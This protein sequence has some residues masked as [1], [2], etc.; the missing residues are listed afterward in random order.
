MSISMY[1][2][3]VLPCVRMLGNL[4]SI[5]QKGM[6]HAEAKKFDPAA[7]V[8]SRLF[9]DM[10]PL[11]RQVQIATDIAKGGLGRLA[12][13]EIPVFEDKETTF[14]ELME[15]LDRTIA[16]IESIKPEQL[17]GSE[18]RPLIMKT[19]RGGM[20]FDSGLDYLQHF[21]LPNVY[22]HAATTYNLLRH[23][24]VEVGKS[25]FIGPVRFV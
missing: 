21:V 25:D 2:A 16:F 12:G 5:L 23:N 24:G 13:V 8:G 3:S 10:F 11:S 19:P 22:F 18:S 17:D 15:R 1:Q 9:P 20:E 14:P 6:A 4:K 7:L